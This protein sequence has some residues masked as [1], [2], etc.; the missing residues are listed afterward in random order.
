M[1]AEA[2]GCTVG[3]V[4]GDENN[5]KLTHPSDWEW[6]LPLLGGTKMKDKS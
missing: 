1:F 6:M 3:L 2:I 4:S 5:R